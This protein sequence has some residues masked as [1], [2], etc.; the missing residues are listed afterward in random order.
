MAATTTDNGA[1]YIAAF[2]HFGAEEVPLD[3]PEEEEEEQELDP[4]TATGQLNDVDA[5][6]HQEVDQ[7]SELPPHHRCRYY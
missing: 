2:R 3:M 1:N 7:S 5:Q 4:D 6:L